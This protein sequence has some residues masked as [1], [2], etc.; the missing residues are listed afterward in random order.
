MITSRSR[1][2]TPD[3]IR[4]IQ[5]QPGE[6]LHVAVKLGNLPPKQAAAYLDQVRNYLL[7]VFPA[8][9]NLLVTSDQISFTVIQP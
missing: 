3:Q 5:V 7:S 4:S 9:T 8:G 2:L 6:T 1:G